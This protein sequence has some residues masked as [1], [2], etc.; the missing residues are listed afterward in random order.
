[1]TEQEIRDEIE[2]LTARIEAID[3]RIAD[4]N[5]AIADLPIPAEPD[6]E[7]PEP[8]PEPTPVP[9]Q[10]A[11]PTPAAGY[12]PKP[13][14]EVQIRTG[15]ELANALAGDPS[16]GT[17][18]VL[19]KGGD[20]AGTYT[21]RDAG[22]AS[23]P[24]LIRGTRDD[25][26]P[27]KGNILVR[28][29]WAGCA[30]LEFSGSGTKVDIGAVGS[31]V[32]RCLFDRVVAGALVYLSGNAHGRSSIDFN[33]C[34]NIKGPIVRS[35]LQGDPANHRGSRI[36]RNHIQG[37][38]VYGGNE[39][40]VL[41]QSS[42]FK[43]VDLDILDN[44]FEGCL[45]GATNQRELISLKTSG[46]KLKGNTVKDSN[47]GFISSRHSCRYVIEDCW[48]EDGSH[49]VVHG[50]DVTIR[51][52]RSDGLLVRA[53]RGSA[54]SSSSIP[55]GC[56]GAPKSGK[57]TIDRQCTPA[58]CG[59]RRLTITNCIGGIELGDRLSSREAGIAPPKD[60]TLK[61][62]DQKAKR[63]AGCGEISE[64]DVGQ[65]NCT[66]RQLTPAQVGRYA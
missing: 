11:E 57:V 49:I 9:P 20:F 37:H 59:A 13:V 34:T 54:Y 1:M 62:N 10:P 18:F 63:F 4:I 29:Q 50:D 40:V 60:I 19:A 46:G 43:N 8:E 6:P 21:L 36:Q 56:A 2:A 23:D 26:V 17:H 25:P 22:T 65:G 24:I 35:E 12:I 44:L 58:H 61:G 53:D 55:P 52:C 45:K 7:P 32:T 39:L 30:W 14:K 5:S 16:P 33:T 64:T 48:F 28:A 31:R 66:A 51:N 3:Q 15:R 42:E 47:R 38:S 27:F 41:V